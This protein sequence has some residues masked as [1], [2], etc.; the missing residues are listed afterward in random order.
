VLLSFAF[1]VSAVLWSSLETAVAAV[2][3]VR[4]QQLVEEDAPGAKNLQRLMENS[5]GFLAT[6]RMVVTATLVGATTL[7]VAAAGGPLGAALG[8]TVGA[9]LLLVVATLAVLLLLVQQV[10]PALGSRQAEGIALALA[11][12]VRFTVWILAPL[13]S[14]LNWIGGLIYAPPRP[15]GGATRESANTPAAV[16]EAQIMLQV[17][18]AEEEGVL[19]E[20][21]G[22][23]IRSIFEFGDT[24]AREV[25]VPR[26]DVKAVP[27]SA[28]LAESVDLAIATGHSRIPVF[29]ETIDDI[30]GIF[31]VKDSLRFFR[32]GRLD[33]HV[34]EVMRQPHFVP[35]T[36]K[37]DDLLSE[38]QSRRVHVAIIVDEYGGTAGL[39]T[40]EDILEE[41]VG[42]IQDEFD[43]EESPVQQISEHEVVVDALMTLDDVNDLLSLDLKEEDVDTLGGLVYARL[44]RVP[45]QGDEVVDGRARLIVDEVEGNRINKVRIITPEAAPPGDQHAT[46]GERRSDA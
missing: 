41:I 40:I 29:G 27:E 45:Q 9:L 39:L 11:A 17:D 3:R 43:A 42:E 31:Y 36:K 19:E 28:T 38:M 6:A 8:S 46:N 1:L 34:R 10:G 18:V 2:R 5:I 25:M 37:V 20:D 4:V 30:T 24:A 44:G 33:I 14:L 15:A 16:T 22:E 26:I 7:V 32:E 21:E 13:V 12:P 23:M 35:E